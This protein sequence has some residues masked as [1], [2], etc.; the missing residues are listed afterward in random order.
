MAGTTTVA[1][2]CTPR[3]P[4]GPG[5]MTA[6]AHRFSEF[7]VWVC[8]LPRPAFRG[9]RNHECLFDGRAGTDGSLHSSWCKGMRAPT[10]ATELVPMSRSCKLHESDYPPRVFRKRGTRNADYSP[11]ESG[12]A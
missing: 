3:G 11:K 7:R 4:I 12:L 2:E 6:Q 8:S 1:D 10:R 9:S 5:L